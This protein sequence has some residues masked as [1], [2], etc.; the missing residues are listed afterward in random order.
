MRQSIPINAGGLL[1]FGLLTWALAGGGQQPDS[2]ASFS[3]ATVRFEQN[4]TDGDVEVVFEVTGDDG[5]LASLSIVAPDGRT[6][7]SFAAPDRSTMGIR[8]FVLESPEPTD[9]AAL[10]AA[11][12]EG[13]Y[14]FSGTTTAGQTLVGTATLSHQLPGTTTFD[15]PTEDAKDVSVRDLEITWTATTDAVAYLIELE[16]EGSET[17]IMVKL[18]ASMNRFSVPNGF[19]QPGKEYQLGI[20]TISKSGNRSFIETSFETAEN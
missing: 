6:V 5:G 7:A 18:P 15:R 11:Y 10:K 8:Q 19:M 3:T 2:A 1:A 20:G 4:A 16:E 12:P 13:V 9:V 17:S 14:N